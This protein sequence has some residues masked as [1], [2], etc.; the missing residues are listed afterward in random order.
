MHFAK[1]QKYVREKFFLKGQNKRRRS[2]DFTMAFPEEPSRILA[3]SLSRMTKDV[4]ARR[5]ECL[6]DVAGRVLA[7]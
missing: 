6:R 3:S 5:G 1:L 4:K 7:F 2:R